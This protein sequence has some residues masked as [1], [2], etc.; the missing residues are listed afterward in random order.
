MQPYERPGSA[1]RAAAEAVGSYFTL[2]YLC[3]CV[4]LSEDGAWSEGVSTRA[5]TVMRWVMSRCVTESSRQRDSARCGFSK[6]KQSGRGSR[7]GPTPKGKAPDPPPTVDE[8]FDGTWT[9]VD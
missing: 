7:D 6:M 9:A 4:G 2:M 5:D 3:A 1:A 8:R